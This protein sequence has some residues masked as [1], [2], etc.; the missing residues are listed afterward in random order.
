MVQPFYVSPSDEAAAVRRASARAACHVR[1]VKV[2]CHPSAGVSACVRGQV[3][4]E[5]GWG[6]ARLLLALA[7]ED[8]RT[9][10]A[11]ALAIELRAGAANEED[12]ARTIHAFVLERVKFE[13]EGME[14]FESGSYTLAL[15]SGDCDAHFRLAYA[16]AV[17]G[18]L[19]AALGILWHGPSAPRGED[20]PA[21]AVVVYGL[22]G[23]WV[24]GE[25]T[26]AAAFGEQPNAAA[27]RLGLTTGRTDIAKE[28]RIMTEDDL[29]PLP[30]NFRERN[31]PAQVALDA[32]ALQRLGYL[33]PDAPACIMTDPTAVPL[34]LAVLAFQQAQGIVADGLLGPTTR[35]TLAHALT[36]SG[37]E[38]FGY[39]GI[40]VLAPLSPAPAVTVVRT[41][42][43]SPGFFAGV[44]AMAAR[45][46]ARGASIEPADLL[47]VWLAESGIRN[48]PNR[49]GYPFGG[50]NQM[51]PNE[52]RSAG[53]VGTFADWL[54]LT[55]EG[56]LPYVER[57]FV[58]GR[59][60]SKYDGAPALYLVNFHPADLAHA[61]EPDFVLVTRNPAGPMPTAP[62]S[63]W[64]PWRKA[65]PGDQYAANLGLDTNRD[66]T[67][68]VGE[69]GA[70]LTA[71]QRGNAVY[72]S[73][74]LARLGADEEAP[75]SVVRSAVVL[76]MGGVAAAAAAAYWYA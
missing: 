19:P 20:G 5:D 31:D 45:M 24:F 74:V 43:L 34:R 11:R 55:C 51:G 57:Y 29:S 22:G 44:R 67:I 7:I 10:G 2:D 75:T 60:V 18:G 64:A 52:R 47:A 50:L 37:T 61:N 56:Q 9:P 76:L 63:E 13:A 32:Q 35:L 23:Q 28:L 3:E 72:W 15:G 54:A 4:C 17:A 42:H 30:A 33:D 26:V 59:D 14:E 68:R 48:V 8:A 38:G 65:H 58:N 16:L 69:L 41:G 49:Q 12:F 27:S 1:R 39:P 6:A 40:G 21:H 66:G 71:A 25:T 46:N 36:A 73:E 62:E 53:F 70:V